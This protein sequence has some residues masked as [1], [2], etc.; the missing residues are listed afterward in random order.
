MPKRPR[1]Y[2]SEILVGIFALL[3]CVL[4]LVLGVPLRRP[5]SLYLS[6]V[7]S[8]LAWY[9]CGLVVSLSALRLLHIEKSVRFGERSRWR[10]TWHEYRERFLSFRQL[11]PDLRLVHAV[12]L[13]FVVFINL[14]HF[15]P[16]VNGR[17]YD[18]ELAKMEKILCGGALASQTVVELLG[19]Q[20]APIL[21]EGYALFF[22]YLGIIV[23]TLILQRDARLK[24]EFCFAFSLLWFVGLL[25]V[26]FFPTYGPCF[27]F[28]QETPSFGPTT[29]LEMQEGLWRQRCFVLS[30]PASSLGAFL[31]SGFPSLHLGAVVLGSIYA[32][33]LS[34][35]L[36]LFSWLFAALTFVTTIYFG[37]HYLADDVGAVV[38]ALLIVRVSNGVFGEAERHIPGMAA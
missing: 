7:G 3:A 23:C 26:Y 33:R 21:A 17:L 32:Q 11:L 24:Q 14:K 35:L 6:K 8:G 34:S 9:C 19:K 20:W 22:P 36:A 15:I 5:F 25:L 4:S 30:N 28:P 12:G 2:P 16:F 38:L 10:D 13:T 29:V 27:F 1:I 18:S 31:I 37:W